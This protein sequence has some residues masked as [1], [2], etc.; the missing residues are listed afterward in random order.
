MVRT[1]KSGFT[2]LVEAHPHGDFLE[3]KIVASCK[4]C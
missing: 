1:A 3:V 4:L 2:L